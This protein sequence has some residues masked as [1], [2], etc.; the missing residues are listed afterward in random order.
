VCPRRCNSARA[1]CATGPSAPQTRTF[2]REP[3]SRQ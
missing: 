3:P 2:I 1:A